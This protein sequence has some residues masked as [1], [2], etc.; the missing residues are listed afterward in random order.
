MVANSAVNWSMMQA[1]PEYVHSSLQQ[2]EGHIWVACGSNE[3]TS[4]L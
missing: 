3:D 1:N 2:R 4:T